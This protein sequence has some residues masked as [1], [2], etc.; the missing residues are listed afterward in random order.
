MSSVRIQNLSDE[1]L[2]RE[3]SRFLVPEFCASGQLR[4]TSSTRTGVGSRRGGAG[5][6]IPPEASPTPK[7]RSTATWLVALAVC[8]AVLILL[9]SLDPALE[10]PPPP[11]IAAVVEGRRRDSQQLLADGAAAARW[12]STLAESS[13]LTWR[14]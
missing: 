14:R 4:G 13:W 11:P 7:A 12:N 5:T 3:L 1:E 9:L 2:H 6:P 8:C 10:R